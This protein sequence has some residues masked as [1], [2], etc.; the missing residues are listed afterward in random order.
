LK[1]FLTRMWDPDENIANR[2]RRIPR[3]KESLVVTDKYDTT[4]CSVVFRK[5]SLLFRMRSIL[6]HQH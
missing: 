6:Q 2:L 4:C 3:L 1:T 5:A